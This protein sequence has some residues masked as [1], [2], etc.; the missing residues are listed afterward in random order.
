M[1]YSTQHIILNISTPE[2]MLT[3]NITATEMTAVFEYK[4]FKGSMMAFQTFSLPSSFPPIYTLKKKEITHSCCT[5]DSFTD[6]ILY[7]MVRKLTA[8]MYFLSDIIRCSRALHVKTGAFLNATQNSLYQLT[9]SISSMFPF[10]LSVGP[11][12]T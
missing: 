1:I 5:P 10:F 4:I 7:T 2:T 9:R 12:W 8:E 11:L 6:V 3:N